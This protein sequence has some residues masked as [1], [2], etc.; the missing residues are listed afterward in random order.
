MTGARPGT[1][2][3]ALSVAILSVATLSVTA[4][5]V[6]AAPSALGQSLDWQAVS[7][8]GRDVLTDA[9]AVGLED[10]LPLYACRAQAGA[11]V[12]LGRYRAD[13]A[14]CHIGFGGKEIS[15]APFEVL[16][17]AWRDA[18]DG[19]IP[20][21]SLD[22]GVRVRAR[23]TGLFGLDPLYSCRAAY[24]GGVQVGEIAAG[25][26]GCGFGFG[27][28]QVTEPHYQVLWQ[29][30]WMTWVPGIAHQLVPG[31]VAGGT[32]GGELFYVCRAADQTGLH[33]GKV[34]PSSPGCGIA[35]DGKEVVATQF[36]LL[37][38][39][40]IEGNAGTLPVTALPAGDEQ[41]L[42][43]LCRARIRG[44]VEVG[45]IDEQLGACHVG[46]L[47]GEIASQAYEVLSVR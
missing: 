1:L 5:S 25:D 16:A 41:Y 29:A 27:G 43:Y 32:E 39:R 17:P 19:A 14:G 3:A 47:G 4:L 34:K 35:S 11:G 2:A 7:G 33:P 38:P 45:K 20:A 36:S 26:R 24:Q 44:A 15:V 40:W 42:L 37:V 22:G 31:A 12:H 23:P 46:M 13:F 10:Q 18:D 21:H 6:T 9:V 28:R 8:K 30:P